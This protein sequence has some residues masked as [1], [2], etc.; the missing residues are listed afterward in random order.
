MYVDGYLLAVP[1]ANKDSYRE[2]A[3]AMAL[4]FKQH[5]ALN[6]VETWEE[7][8]PEGKLTS[9][10]M[11]VKRE[12]GEAIVFSWVTWPSKQVRDEGLRKTMDI[13]HEMFKDAPIPF[14]GKRMIFGGFESIVEA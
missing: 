6:V 14:D 5:G 7:D 8:V 9:F 10:P 13:G 11:A 4:L 3:E 12:P 2:M 1:I